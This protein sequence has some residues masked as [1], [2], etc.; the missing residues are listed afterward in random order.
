MGLS[1]T[2]AR[3]IGSAG[4]LLDRF[5]HARRT[6]ISLCEPLSP[7]DMV[8]Q[9]FEHTSPTKWHLAHTT[10]FFETFILEA[11]EPG[12]EAYDR[13][14]RVLFNSYYQTIG[15]RHPRAKRGMLTRPGLG[16]VM[17]YRD[18]VDERV[19]KL[20]DGADDETLR[21]ILPLLELGIQHEQQHQELLLMDIKRTLFE[22]PTRPAYS[23]DGEWR[24]V[25]SADVEPEWLAI[26]G[27]IVEIGHPATDEA[28]GDFAFD[29]ECARHERLLEPFELRSHLVTNREYIAFIEDGGYTRPEL[30]LDDAWATICSEGWDKPL[31][32]QKAKDGS[33]GEYTLHGVRPLDPNAPVVHI[34]FYEATAFARWAGARLPTEAEWEAAIAPRWEKSLENAQFLEDGALHPLATTESQFAGG[35]WEWTRSAHEPYPRYR[36]PEGPVGEYNGKFM[37][38]SYVLRGGSCVTSRDHI[39]LTYRNFFHPHARWAF[40]GLRLA[41]NAD[42]D[43]RPKDHMTSSGTKDI[44]TPSNLRPLIVRDGATSAFEQDMIEALGQPEGEKAIPPKHLY[45]TRGSELF[46]Q[47]TDLEEYYPSTIETEILE[48]KA[49]DIAEAIGPDAIIIEPGAGAAVK[50]PILL[51]ALESPRMFV[52]IE[53]SESAVTQSSERLAQ[54]FRQLTV[55]PI[56]AGFYEGLDAIDDADEPIPSENRVLYFPGSTIGNMPHLER[57]RLLRA[58]ADAAGEGGRILLGVDMVKDRDVMIEAYDDPKGVSAKFGRNLITRL[59]NELGAGLDEG[60][61]HYEAIWSDEHE[62]IEMRLVCAYPQTATIGGREFPIAEGEAITTEH[63]CKF[64][65]ERIER[66]ARGA[67]LK[68]VAMWTDENEWF[69]MV[70]LERDDS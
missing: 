59:N 66:E 63:S 62:R 17:A 27:G 46:E 64:T 21:Q 25:G 60:A 58:F 54:E 24:G 5:R 47:I 41:R 7:E 15:E 26:E 39:R 36:P 10:W 31:Y 61:F 55:Q 49:G 18:T 56:C 37:C 32:W 40:A 43:S 67:G 51:R 34:S 50:V 28:K 57:A 35:V 19:I 45:D 42:P 13:D 53:I 48:Q 1:T 38:G 65:R 2:A 16:E 9:A 20:I 6:T 4:S 30:W 12:F 29:N 8:V 44:D 14:F 23:V 52:P 3:D 22:N 70:M 11:F 69:A 33:W 68:P